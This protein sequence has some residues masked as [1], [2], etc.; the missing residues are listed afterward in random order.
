MKTKEELEKEF[1]EKYVKTSFFTSHA[2]SYGIIEELLDLFISEIKERD[3]S[4]LVLRTDVEVAGQLYNECKSKLSERE[5]L[6]E[7]YR[8]ENALNIER[9]NELEK[10]NAEL[11]YQGLHNKIM[12]HWQKIYGSIYCEQMV[13][14][15]VV[16]GFIKDVLNSES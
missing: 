8:K 5:K 14:A 9:R 16:S 10:H 6:L 1:I 15:Y 3:N 2:A 4:I 7:E 13:D 12:S 11:E